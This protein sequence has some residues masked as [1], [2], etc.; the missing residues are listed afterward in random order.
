MSSAKEL[1][2]DLKS[3]PI[4]LVPIPANGREVELFTTSDI[5]VDVEI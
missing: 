1:T 5:E 2:K 4:G 3:L